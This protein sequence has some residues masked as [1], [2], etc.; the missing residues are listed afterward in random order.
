[1]EAK[2]SPCRT[3]LLFAADKQLAHKLIEQFAPGQVPA[4]IGTLV[5]HRGEAC[6]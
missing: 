5:R 3:G 2:L 1:M 4:A 6:R